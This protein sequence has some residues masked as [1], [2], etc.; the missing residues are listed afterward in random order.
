MSNTKHTPGPWAFYPKY[1]GE[2][3]VAVVKDLLAVAEVVGSQGSEGQISKETAI[4][5]AKL[6]AAAPEMLEAL[7]EELSNREHTWD[8]DDPK[9]STYEAIK[10]L[11]AIIKKATE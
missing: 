4:A 8:A 1:E 7:K 9:S 6:I 11:K 2:H 10:N 5:N 3:A